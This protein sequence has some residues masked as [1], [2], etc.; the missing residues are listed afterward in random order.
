MAEDIVR[1]VLMFFI[2]PLWLAGDLQPAD[3]REMS[4]RASDR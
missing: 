4:G 1:S 3:R 2:L